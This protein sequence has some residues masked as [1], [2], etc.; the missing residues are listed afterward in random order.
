M[1]ADAV[2]ELEHAE[3]LQVVVPRFV[4]VRVSPYVQVYHCTTPHLSVGLRFPMVKWWGFS[5]ELVDMVG[6]IVLGHLDG[7]SAFVHL[8]V[9]ISSFLP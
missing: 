4:V 6:R 8:P 3:E 7:V 2:A 5:L 1:L 9:S